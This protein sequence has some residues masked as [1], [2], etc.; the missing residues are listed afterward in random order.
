[1]GATGNGEVWVE[2]VREVDWTGTI[3]VGA[4]GWGMIKACVHR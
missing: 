2:V 1:M 3:W 4:T